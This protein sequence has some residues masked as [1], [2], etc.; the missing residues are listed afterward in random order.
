MNDLSTIESK[1]TGPPDARERRADLIAE[2]WQA[3]AES[4]PEAVSGELSRRM[5]KLAG[6]FVARLRELKNQL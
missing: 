5:D 4:G 6:E 2:L 3:F 1:L